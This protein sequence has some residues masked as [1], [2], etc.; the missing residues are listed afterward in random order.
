MRIHIRH[1]RCSSHRIT[2]LKSQGG[3]TLIELIVSVAII[4]VITSV[5]LVQHGQFNNTL[6]LT[7][8]TYEV[9]LSV[10]EA[11]TLGVS[12]REVQTPSGGV[13]NVSYG[14]F[15]DHAA[16]TQYILFADLNRNN[17]YDSAPLPGGATE[18]VLGFDITRQNRIGDFCGRQSAGANACASDGDADTLSVLF[19]RPNP[20]ALV[21][22]QDGADVDAF[23]AATIYLTSAENDVRCVHIENTGQVSVDTSCTL[24]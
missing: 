8:L 22:V 20:D 17:T 1:T 23:D 13:G 6:A 3:F 18:L 7:N 9:A 24:P 16:P 21:Y 2:G 4:A 10:R 5:A 14:V 12:A 11:Q 15:F 19:E